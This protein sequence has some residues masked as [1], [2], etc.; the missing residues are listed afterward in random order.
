MARKPR[1]E[2]EGGVY[3]VI[4]RGN[5]RADI[6]GA[7]RTKVAFLKCLGETCAKTGWRVHAWCIMSNHYHL[8]VETPQANLVEGMQWLQVTFSVRFNRL[9]KECGHLFQGRYKGLRVDPSGL[10]ALCH[11][12]HLNPV[13]AGLCP[14]E[15]LDGWPWSSMAWLMDPVERQAWFD[16]MAALDHAGGLKDTPAGRR[17]Y[18]EYLAWLMEDEPARK[19]L[20]FETMSKGWIVGTKGFI[21]AVIADHKDA[22]GKRQ[23]LRASAPAVREEIWSETLAGLL[24]KLK[25]DPASLAQEGKSVPWKL[26]LAAALKARTTVTNRWLGQN[27][28]MGNLHEVSRKVS[29]WAKQPDS[30]LTKRL[31]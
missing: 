5:Y 15:N 22:A 18:G 8:A 11:Y 9:R 12:I 24:R 4:N 21:K 19:Q 29:A 2:S 20:G 28:H 14:A 3:H 27:L 30:G 1:L 10:G 13:R 7:Q 25:R 6:F 31:Q 23:L 16:P 26:A 17:K